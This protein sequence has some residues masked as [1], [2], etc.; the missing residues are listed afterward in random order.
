M[1]SQQQ[2][3]PV[4]LAHTR[5]FIPSSTID[6][7]VQRRWAVSIFVLLQAWK[8]TDLFTVY[9]AAYPEQYNGIF[10]KWFLIDAIYMLA[11]YIAKIPWLQFSALKTIFLTMLLFW[12]NLIL[13]SVPSVGLAGI[14]FK[15]FFGDVIG[16][17]IGVSS[18]RMVNVKDIVQNSSHILGRHAVHILPYG[19]AKL[20]A[21]N[22]F[23]C[24]S[25]DGSNNQLVY[26]P[27]ILNNTVPKSVSLARY[28][29]D[30]N[31]KTVKEYKVV[32]PQ[33]DARFKGHRQSHKARTCLGQDLSL[34]VE[35]SGDGPFELAW[36]VGDQLYSDV[37]ENKKYTIKLPP[38]DQPG[39]FVVSLVRIKDVNMCIKELEARDFT[40]DVRHD[41]PTASF[42]GEEKAVA[43]TEGSTA[44][45]PLRLTGEGPW[46]VV[47]YNVEKGEHSKVRKVFKDPNAEIEVRSV[48]HYA[49][50]HVEDSVC[51]GDV[52]GA[53]YEVKWIDK[54]V[55][56]IAEGQTEQVSSSVY[57]RPA[58]C[59][60]DH[61]SIDILFSGQGPFYCSYEE[62][63][64]APRKRH[65]EKLGTE[66]ITTGLG[67]VHLPLKTNQG[68]KYRYVFDRLADQRYS[69]PF[70]IRN[71]EVHQ[72]VHSNPTVKFTSRTTR[73]SY[74]LC[75]GDNLMFDKA[76][77][78]EIELTGQAPFTVELG[79]RH[80]S[81]LNGRVITLSDIMTERY[82]I[83][84]PDELETAGDYHLQLL[85]VKDANGCSTAVAETEHTHIK[86]NALDI[87]TITP[88]EACSDSCVGDNLEFSLSGVAPFTISYLFN[89][90]TEYVKS[91]TSRLSMIA[92]KPGNL[93]IL[94]VGDKRNKCRS[95]PKDMSRIIH[96]VPSSRVSGG[97]EILENIREGDMVQAVVDLIG[98]PPFDFEWRRSEL[99]W[100]E[101]RKRHFKGKALESHL[102]YD[103]QEHQYVINTSV[104]GI[105]EVVSIKDRYCQYPRHH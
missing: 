35:L 84:L 77:P 67:R 89:G 94:S 105:I 104:E 30:T 17:Q 83:R 79:I 98:T 3:R 44:Q 2:G 8:A 34:D 6:F 23:Y 81:D 55:I 21:N 100:D 97:R 75:V 54:P 56:T 82:E 48:G 80:Q 66:E 7:P 49:L 36:T 78:L 26:I 72:T 101:Q 19:T 91:T 65:F 95:F 61:D 93:T 64:Q 39:H 51:P 102:V 74:S 10:F 37:A 32:R 68:G 12:I 13:F 43:V 40:I 20:N 71:L 29:F 87:A 4:P 22:D 70:K 58:V 57:E 9:Q 86:L 76:Q 11:L 90:K 88:I 25:P 38:F 69:D 1:P 96:E 63:Y 47:Y 45:L 85:R 92:D 33:P 50:A 27:I 24:I 62:Q 99:I 28:E 103:V 15:N 18:A 73:N 41:R 42:A 53:Q 59:Q 46:S 52:S 16:Q 14:L 31:E 60:G 5:A